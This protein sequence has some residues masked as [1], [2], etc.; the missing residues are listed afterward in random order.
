MLE[1]HPIEVIEGVQ[2]VPKVLLPNYFIKFSPYWPDVLNVAGLTAKVTVEQ[3]V[4]F[5]FSF[6]TKSG[7]YI[8]IDLSDNTG[9]GAYPYA[10]TEMY[11]MLIGFKKGN[12]YAVPYFEG[13]PVYRLGYQKMV[14]T[15]SDPTLKHLGE[16][17]PD[18]SPVSDAILK[19]YLVYNCE[20]VVLQMVADEGSDYVKETIVMQINR[21]A[22][23]F[24]APVPANV[25]PKYLT[26]IL[27]DANL[28]VGG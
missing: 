20:P 13:K 19:L 21:C 14:N 10:I 3:Q 9:I 16:I 28:K 24:N 6:K 8:N 27:E 7:V 15:L 12:Y 2:P 1:L 4:R 25:T 11:E 18:D 26:Y 22:L 23:D 17:T 5:P